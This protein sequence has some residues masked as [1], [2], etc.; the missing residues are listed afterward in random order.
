MKEAV[1]AAD[2]RPYGPDYAVGYQRD[3][4]QKAVRT[5]YVSIGGYGPA[6]TVLAS[7][8]DMA[9]YLITQAQLGKTPDGNRV[10]TEEN[11][12]RTHQPGVLVPPD[13]LNALPAALLVDTKQTNYALGWFDEEFNDGHRMLWHAGGID[14][15]GSLMG[16]L[17]QH[18]LGF[19]SLTNNEP[20]V[21]GLFNFCVQSAFL[22][23]LL[24]LNSEIPPLLNTLP[25]TLR[26]QQTAA[27]AS[28][29]AVG[30]AA[31]EPYLGLYENGFFLA[32]DGDELELRHDIRRLRVR[33]V[34][35]GD[36][37]I[38]DGPSVVSG[39]KL[40][41]ATHDAGTRTMTIDGFDPVVWLS[42]V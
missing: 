37:L 40:T 10:A 13:S 8:T 1:V 23:V 4:A 19:V 2:P 20:S 3:L 38:V 21:G 12:R 7:S 25:A 33:H 42:G 9:R 18:R 17:P 41:L 32:L 16:F 24:G 34:G 39:K 29:R 6:G 14:G 26:K 28:T 11:V 30:A 31:V 22:E 36:Y 5:P 27:L 15:F 35:A